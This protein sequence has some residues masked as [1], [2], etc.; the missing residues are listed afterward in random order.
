MIPGFYE[1]TGLKREQL[2]M[3]ATQIQDITPEGRVPIPIV[4]GVYTLDGREVKLSDEVL[5]KLLLPRRR[6]VRL[7]EGSVVDR[8][9]DF[10]NGFRI[11]LA[12][13]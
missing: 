9:F 2:P 7:S 10:E 11:E 5:E 8:V 1:A 12:S 4:I 3:V 6:S 13:Q